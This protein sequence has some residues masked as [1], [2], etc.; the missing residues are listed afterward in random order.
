VSDRLARRAPLNRE[1]IL[2]TAVE[3]CDTNGLGALT[4]R[5]L[6]EVL[7]VEAMSLYHYVDD[8]EDLLS[9]IVDVV[10]SKINLTPTTEEWASAIRESAV[11]AH[12]VL[13]RH[14]W[15]CGLVLSPDSNQIAPA[16]MKWIESILARF[17]LAG[18]SPAGAS[19]GYHAIDSHVL[20]FT[21]W[22]L[23]HSPPSDAPPDYLEQ[24]LSTFDFTGYPYLA[25]HA[26]EHLR[27]T[28]GPATGEFE[29]GLDLI[30]DGLARIRTT[31]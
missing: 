27:D 21:L 9:G 19:R 10:L 1:R 13:I 3:L 23:G 25:E 17:R 14:P 7:G 28:D 15:S 16:R 26:R 29:F 8:K 31:A 20:G 2:E 11:S 18:F 6:G 22:E 4:M 24:I 12:E 30:L 5:R